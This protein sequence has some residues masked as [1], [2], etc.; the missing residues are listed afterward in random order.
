MKK[1]LLAL[2]SFSFLI[3][4]EDEMESIGDQMSQAMS[5]MTTKASDIMSEM[6]YKMKIMMFWYSMS[7]MHKLILAG[8]AALLVFWIVCKI[9]HHRKGGSCSCGCGKGGC[10]CHSK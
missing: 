6:S 1:L 9:M 3:K 8:L 2:S 5:D 4:A 10:G 7:T